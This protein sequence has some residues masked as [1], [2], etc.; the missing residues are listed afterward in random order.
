[1]EIRIPVRSTEP[2]MYRSSFGVISK[3]ILLLNYKRKFPAY[4][5][6]VKPA[7]PASENKEPDLQYS[8]EP[9]SDH[10]VLCHSCS[11]ESQNLG[12]PNTFICQV[13]REFHSCNLN[14]YSIHVQQ[15]AITEVL[16]SSSLPWERVKNI[17]G[18]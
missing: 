14:M 17:T 1:M 15:E 10:K 13:A 11:Q 6:W 8:S 9:L 16:S 7:I 12:D 18:N 3:I 5:T 4:I 2:Y